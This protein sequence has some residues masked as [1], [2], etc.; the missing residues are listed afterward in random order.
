MAQSGIVT[1][2]KEVQSDTRIITI[3][4][5]E[6]IEFFGGQFIIADS[7]VPIEDGKTA[8]GAFTIISK[9]GMNNEISI[10]VKKLE[11]GPC[12]TY[13]NNILKVGDSLGI[14]GP[15]GAAKYETELGDV[16]SLFLATDTGITSLIGF[17]NGENAKACLDKS[18]IVWFV[19][20][21]DYFLTEQEVRD[22]LPDQIRDSLVVHHIAAPEFATRTDQAL[23]ILED[24]LKGF[25][26]KLSYLVGDG[27]VLVPVQDL[28]QEKGCGANITT[29]YFFNNPDKKGG[30]KAKLRKGFTTGACSAAAAR[31]SV[32]A[33]LTREKVKNIETTLPN[34]QKNTFMLHSCSIESNNSAVSSIIKDAGDDPDCTHGAEIFVRVELRKDNSEIEIVGGE[35][36]GMVTKPGLGLE[37]GKHA[38]N[39]IPRKNIT[40]MIREELEESSYSGALVTIAVPGGDEM[41]KKTSSSRLGILGGISILGTSGIVKPY[42]TA[43]Y[44]ASIVQ[45]IRIAA[46]EK[47][48]TIILTTGGRSEKYAMEMYPQYGDTAFVQ[49]GDFI[50]A[51]LKAARSNGIQTAIIVSMMGK[52]SKMADGQTQTHIAGSSVNMELLARLASQLGA[53]DEVQTQMLAANTARHVLEISDEHKLEG[54]C[55]LI[56]KTTCEKMSD[57]V[58]NKVHVVAHLMDFGGDELGIYPPR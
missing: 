49:C 54:L 34:K 18:R 24:I 7:G 29:E 33:I 26:P 40:Q 38:I 43:S 35:G 9:E 27:D 55:E 23:N 39:P 5:E 8:K 19:A 50:G 31:A 41:A 20:T 42:S 25:K 47:Y 28:L 22:R 11:A 37:V 45:Q 57:F 56:C 16:E 4:F 2:I 15:W 10:A 3:R 51:S 12:T 30:K 13:M 36:I 46:L 14:S 17:L 32:R 44:R 58:D 52:L 48:D 6:N 21:D 1:E 53:S